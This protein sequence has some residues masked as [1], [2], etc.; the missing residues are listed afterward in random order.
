MR[1]SE[2]VQPKQRDIVEPKQRAPRNPRILDPG[3][4]VTLRDIFAAANVIK[5]CSA[6]QAFVVADEML[7]ERQKARA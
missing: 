7:A 2:K 5:G 6:A 4:E 3:S 1:S